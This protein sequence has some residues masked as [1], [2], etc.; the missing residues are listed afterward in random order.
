EATDL[1][2]DVAAY[3]Q[4]LGVAQYRAGADRAA[5]AAFTESVK[6]GKGG[7]ATDWLFLAMAH[8]KRGNDD[9]ARKWF[10]QADQWMENNSEAVKNAPDRADELNRLVGEAEGILGPKKK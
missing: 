2:P 10:D 4:T 6:L 1:R 9:Q 3:W 8:K 5:L 7:D